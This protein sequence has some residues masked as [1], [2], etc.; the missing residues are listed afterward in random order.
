MLFDLCCQM[1]ITAMLC[2][3]RGMR[4]TKRFLIRTR[5]YMQHI[6]IRFQLLG[7]THP[8]GQIISFFDKF[9]PAHAELYREF[10][11][12]GLT[13]SPQDFY[14]KTAAILQ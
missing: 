1:H 12:Y 13:H 5:T 7:N 6:H 3:H 2:K 8:F 14:G 11:A 4:N 10:G 9:S